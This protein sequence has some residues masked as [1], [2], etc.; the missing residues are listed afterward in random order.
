MSSP[1]SSRQARG[2]RRRFRP[3]RL[4]LGL[5]LVAVVFAAGLSLGRALDEGPAP[6]GTRTFERTL[7]P[8]PLSPVSPPTTITVTATVTEPG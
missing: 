8:L 1:Q 2:R 5:A 7:K 6:G 3:L 4:V